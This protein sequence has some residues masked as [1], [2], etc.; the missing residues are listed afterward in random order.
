MKNNPIEQGQNLRL[1]I[2]EDNSD[3]VYTHAW[4]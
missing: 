3:P 4:K 2:L 1:I